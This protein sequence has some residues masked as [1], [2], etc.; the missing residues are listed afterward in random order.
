MVYHLKIFELKT[1]RK[2][3]LRRF[4]YQLKKLGSKTSK[5]LFA[6]KN[7][8]TSNLLLQPKPLPLHV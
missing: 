6:L 2:E 7:L 1:Q 4:F 5:K 3:V 8:R